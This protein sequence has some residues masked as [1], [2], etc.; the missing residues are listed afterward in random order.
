MKTA[1]LATV[2]VTACTVL[3]A[4]GCRGRT[5]AKENEG[6]AQAERT[7]ME[8][9]HWSWSFYLQTCNFGDSVRT[10][11]HPF[12]N[13]TIIVPIDN[14][15]TKEELKA[16]QAVFA[17]NGIE[18]PEPDGEGYALYGDDGAKLRFLSRDL[19]GELPITG[20]V[21][22]ITV[23]ELTDEFLRIVL[24]VA[25]CG[26]L[27]L[28]SSVGDQ[29]RLVERIPTDSQLA[30]WPDA[31]P[32]SSVADLRAS[33]EHDIGGTQVHVPQPGDPYFELLQRQRNP[34]K[35]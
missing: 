2:C 27:A 8:L 35:L 6:S 18:G 4:G 20:M 24:D 28:T 31:K 29:V 34:K 21:V 16:V 12:A 26:N 10:V 1:L 32:V 17:E 11:P 22:E 33:L 14:G 23:K 19:D 3:S 13:K 30:R 25:R 15:L 9:T 7:S 5:P